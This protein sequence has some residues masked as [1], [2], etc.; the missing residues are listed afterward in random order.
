ML[1]FD[2]NGAQNDMKSFY[3]VIIFWNFFRASLG[4]FGQKSFAPAKICLLHLW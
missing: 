4:E 3:L 2:K 1:L